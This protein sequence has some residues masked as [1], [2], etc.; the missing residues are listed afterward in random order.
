MYFELSHYP[1]CHLLHL[2]NE[3]IIPKIVSFVSMNIDKLLK[4]IYKSHHENELCIGARDG[5]KV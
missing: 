5:N 3:D 4:N 2:S 1:F